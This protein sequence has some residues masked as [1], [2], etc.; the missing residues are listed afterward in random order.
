MKKQLIFSLVSILIS[1]SITIGYIKVTKNKIAYIRTE[2]LIQKYKG[3]QDLEKKIALS[4]N[5]AQKINPGDSLGKASAEEILYNNQVLVQG[6]LNQI[7]DY[8]K[9]YAEE[10]NYTLILGTTNDGNLLFGNKGI[11][12][13]EDILTELNNE[14]V[15]K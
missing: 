13:T 10:N 8:I 7:N 4:K 15:G 14:Y 12:V 11:D 5:S 3:Y 9:K 6:V 2:Y 1:C